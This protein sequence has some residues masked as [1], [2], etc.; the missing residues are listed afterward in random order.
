MIYIAEYLG[1]YNDRHNIEITEK[2]VSREEYE[3]FFDNFKYYGQ[4]HQF[5]EIYGI[6][7]EGNLDLMKFLSAENLNAVLRQKEVDRESV[8]QTGNKLL[9]NYCTVIKIMVEKIESFLKR[10]RPDQLDGFRKFCSNFYD[11]EFSYRFFMRLRNYTI[12]NGMPF[13]KI[14]SSLQKDCN[15]Y[16]DRNNLL[17]WSGWSTVKR[18]LEEMENDDIELQPFLLE[19]G[20]LIYAIYL[21]SLY[22]LAPDLIRAI[23]NIEKFCDKYNVKRFDFIEYEKAEELRDGKYMHHIVP[24]GRWM[25][26]IEEFN[27]HP[28][29]EI[30]FSNTAK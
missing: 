23:Q 12:H 19:I 28:G 8:L 18:D 26:S 4:Y 15:L 9:L 30:T 29:I 27:K 7:L 14:T 24:W 13:T 20:S 1:Y 21:Q 25:Q 6:C 5:K 22:Y 2:S 11:S 17:K 10:K 3:A 16:I